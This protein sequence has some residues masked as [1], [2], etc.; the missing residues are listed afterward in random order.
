MKPDIKQVAESLHERKR[1][2][3]SFSLKINNHS[4]Q[5]K[6]RL[7]EEQR[8]IAKLLASTIKEKKESYKAANYDEKKFPSVT[9]LPFYDID[10]S[11]V[12]Q[13]LG[14]EGEPKL[15]SAERQFAKLKEL[16]GLR[17]MDSIVD[18]HNQSIVPLG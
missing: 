2:V 1:A 17:N 15:A 14:E 11:A 8:K 5:G 7:I 13:E 6:E 9:T 3:A 12:L 4:M 10:Y 18:L 16:F